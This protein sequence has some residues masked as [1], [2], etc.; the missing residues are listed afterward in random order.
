[1][2]TT[3]DVLADPTRRR[4]LGELRRGE[5]SVGALAE[6]TALSQPTVSKQ[7]KVLRDTGWVSVRR[8]AQWR[9]YSLDRAG[10]RQLDAWLEPFR[11]YWAERVDRMEDVLDSLED[12]P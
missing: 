4:L 7:L 9:F 12:R 11:A 6:R 2:L 3:F 5:T 8:D 10:L 1:M